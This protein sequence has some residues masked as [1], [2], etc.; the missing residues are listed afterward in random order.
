MISM[1]TMCSDISN[2]HDWPM[3]EVNCDIQ[4]GIISEI[5]TLI[6]AEDNLFKVIFPSCYN[7]IFCSGLTAKLLLD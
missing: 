3:D 7:K 2:T 5:I 1:N 6:P 4:L